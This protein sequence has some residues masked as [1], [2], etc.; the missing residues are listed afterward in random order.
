MNI[1]HKL[2]L[3]VGIKKKKKKIIKNINIDLYLYFVRTTYSYKKATGMKNKNSLHR[4]SDG[5]SI[6]SEPCV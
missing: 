4:R 1:N 6:Y 2:F 5:I 3:K